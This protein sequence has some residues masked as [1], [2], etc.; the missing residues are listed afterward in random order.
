MLCMFCILFQS[1]AKMSKMIIVQ[2]QA[3]QSKTITQCLMDL[4]EPFHN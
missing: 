4:N 1:V 3:E 2:V